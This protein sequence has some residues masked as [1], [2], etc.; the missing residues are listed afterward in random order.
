MHHCQEYIIV[1]RRAS[2]HHSLQVHHSVYIIY[3]RTSSHALVQQ[4][5]SLHHHLSVY[6]RVYGVACINTSLCIGESVHQDYH[7]SSFFSVDIIS[8]KCTS[9]SVSS[10]SMYAS[11]YHHRVLIT[12]LHST[13][14]KAYTHCFWR[15]CT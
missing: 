3:H 12:T 8:I 4:H 13:K 6:H 5:H 1:H 11:T 2:S 15:H 7:I 10:H 14:A 9:S